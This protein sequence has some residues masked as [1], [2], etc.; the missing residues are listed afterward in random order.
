MTPIVCRAAACL[1][2]LLLALA[3]VPSAFAANYCVDSTNQ[4]R[5]AL[6]SAAT[7]IEDDVVR[8]VRGNYPL[9]SAL[10]GSFNGSLVLRGG[11]A[12]NCPALGRSLDASETR[13][14]GTTVHAALVDLGLRNGDLEIDGLSFEDLA[15]VQVTDNTSGA[16]ANGQVWVRRS[17]F[18]GNEYGLA[19]LTR[20]KNVRVENNLFLNNRSLCCA[21]EFL[22]NGLAVR[23]SAA[24]APDITVDVLFN[25]ILGSPKSLVIQGGAPFSFPPRIQNNILRGTNRPSGYCLKIDATQV[26]ARNNIWCDFLTED[27]GGFDSNQANV[28]ADPLLDAGYVPQ[29]QSPAL[30]SGTALVAGGVSSTDLD[31]GPRTIGS[32]PDRGA[33]ESAISDIL[34]LTVTSTADSGPGTLRQ[35]ILDSNQTVNAELI[36]F[37]IAGTC[38]RVIAPATALPEIVSPLTIDGFTQPGSAPNTA[39]GSYNGDHCI[40]LSGNL[41]HGLRLR[42]D[43]DQSM[44]VRGLSFYGFNVAAIHAQGAGT[45]QIEGNTFG[46][47]ANFFGN[48]FA[49]DAIVLSGVNGSRIGG[50]EPEQ[51]NLIGRAAGAGIW[52]DSGGPRT[53]ENNFIGLTAN[54]YGAA[55]NG[56]GIRVSHGGGDIIERNYIGHSSTQG[57]LVQAGLDHSAF[58]QIRSNY[59]G[60][61]ASNNPNS[62]APRD[63]GNGTNGIRITSGSGHEIYQNRVA[64]NGTDGIVVLGG[65]RARFNANRVYENGQL[66]I[67][68]SPDGVDTQNSDLDV[69]NRGNR[70]QN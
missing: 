48:G 18:V 70:G 60:Y 53:V 38:P 66:G 1:A 26:Y 17:R 57:I 23:H 21:S 30:N 7:S 45:V 34:W 5:T 9:G 68:L 11:Y 63:A 31:G 61:A 22:S 69:T 43:T 65:Y 3:S 29:S 64:Y 10:S 24:D 62:I 44:R 47:G 12:A 19:V 28:D 16:V 52:L 35:A 25:T 54:G 49:G 40:V 59:I 39:T 14:Y 27:G 20:H 56:V 33:L 41:D 8:L 46:S 58:L 13:I 15:G 4:L 55:P 67:D 42:P 50:T 37:D 2:A 32:R 6:A 51:R 36:R